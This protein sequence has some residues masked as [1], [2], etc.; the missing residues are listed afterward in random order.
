MSSVCNLWILANTSPSAWKSS[1][2]SPPSPSPCWLHLFSLKKKKKI[3]WL[4]LIFFFFLHLILAAN[5]SSWR[6]SLQLSLIMYPMCRE[7][8]P[9]ILELNK[10][11]WW[12]GDLTLGCSVK[13]QEITRGLLSPGSG[14]LLPDMHHWLWDPAAGRRPKAQGGCQR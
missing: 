2:G 8:S 13:Q 10:W 11:M 5:E 14:V 1:F 3:I 7:L 6:W 9:L 4:H 12:S